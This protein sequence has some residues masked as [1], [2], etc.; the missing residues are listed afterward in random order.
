MVTRG[1]CS[2]RLS[3]PS[4]MNTLMRTATTRAQHMRDGL[5]FASDLTDAEWAVLEPL[6]PR[7]AGIGRPPEWP[8]REVVN[9]IFYVLRGGIAWRM[10]RPASRPD[11]RCTA[12]SRRGDAPTYGR[13]LRTGW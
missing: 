7:P 11:K 12:G 8:M 5:R 6:L 10:L 9:A 1:C 13:R 3:R 2:N 4:W